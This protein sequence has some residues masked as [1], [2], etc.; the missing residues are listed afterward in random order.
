MS[1]VESFLAELQF[2]QRNLLDGLPIDLG[3]G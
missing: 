3:M 2:E 1:D